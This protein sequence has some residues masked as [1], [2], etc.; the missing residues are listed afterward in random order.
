MFARGL[1]R[2]DESALFLSAKYPFIEVPFQRLA[3][4]IVGLI[5]PKTD[6]G[7]KIIVTMVDNATRY[8]E[9]V[10]LPSIKTTQVAEALVDIFTGAGILREILTDQGSQF[11]SDV[12]REVG[13]LLSIKQLKTTP[14]HPS[15]NGLV[16]RFNGTLKQM[17]KRMCSERP[18]DWDRY[19]A[20]LLI[21]YREAPR[22]SLGFSPFELLYGR[23]VRGPI[24][25][26]ERAVVR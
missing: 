24:N 7:N 13:R 3:V 8:L 25:D 16:E 10:P 12:M 23:T 21:A 11:T 6:K 2:R 20:P 5:F 22:H 15:C 17:L 14:Y 19:V 18:R 4:D 26:T 1:S 9:A